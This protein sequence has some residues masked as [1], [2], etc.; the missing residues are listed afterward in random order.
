MPVKS[1]KRALRKASKRIYQKEYNDAKIAALRDARKRS[2]KQI[3]AKARSKAQKY[4]VTP[5]ER[6]AKC[7]KSM[8]QMYSNINKAHK[9]HS[10][11]RRKATKKTAGKKRKSKQQYVVIAGKA[12]KKGSSGKRKQSSKRKSSPKRK[13]KSVW[14]MELSDMGRF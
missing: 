12:Y 5:V 3:Q 13:T 8:A 9:K 4:N 10:A 7:K 2:R 6:M 1:S 14:D 11:T